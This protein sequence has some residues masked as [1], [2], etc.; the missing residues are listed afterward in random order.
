MLYPLMLDGGQLASDSRALLDDRDAPRNTKVALVRCRDRLAVRWWIAP[1]ELLVEAC[2]IAKAEEDLAT[3][4]LVAPFHLGTRAKWE[5]AL[6]VDA[7]TLVRARPNDDAG[8]RVVFSGTRVIGVLQPPPTAAGAEPPT[9]QPAPEPIPAPSPSSPPPGA[10]PSAP[11]PSAPMPPVPMPSQTM[12][13][14]PV[15]RGPRRSRP[16]HAAPSAAA[17]ESAG[18]S[19]T[20]VPVD[21]ATDT[22]HALARVELPKSLAPGDIATLVVG[23]SPAP[24]PTAEGVMQF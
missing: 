9:P 13:A 19:T 10:P 22:L 5:E 3:A 15:L 11:P 12:T 17:P 14:P 18:S 8:W 6:P 1:L 24:S 20:A 21:H 7:A 4:M 2:T 23:L 16:A